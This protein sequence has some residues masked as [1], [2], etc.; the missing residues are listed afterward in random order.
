MRSFGLLSLGLIT[1]CAN[2]PVYVECPDA[3]V[4]PTCLRSVE[5]GVDDFQIY[6]RGS[7]TGIDPSPAPGVTTVLHGNFPNPFNPMTAIRYDLSASGPVKLRIYDAGGRLVRVLQ[8]GPQAAGPQSVVWDGRNDG[9]SPVA[10][11]V[12]FYRLEAPGFEARDRMVL[13]K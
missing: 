7:T 11:G 13:S 9:A 12:Y 4:D 2:D 3:P 6:E 8:D 1:A 10:S 5:A